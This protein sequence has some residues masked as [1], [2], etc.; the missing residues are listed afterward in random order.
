MTRRN[1]PSLRIIYLL[2]LNFYV[3]LLPAILSWWITSESPTDTAL[4][5]IV[6]AL[7]TGFRAVCAAANGLLCHARMNFVVCAVYSIPVTIR[8]WNLCLRWKLCSGQPPI[9]SSTMNASKPSLSF[10]LCMQ[11]NFFLLLLPTFAS[12]FVSGETPTEGLLAV[13]AIISI[14]GTLL[15]CLA[16]AKCGFFPPGLEPFALVPVVVF[17]ILRIPVPQTILFMNAA[18]S[19][20]VTVGLW[21]VCLRWV[22]LKGR[23][24]SYTIRMGES[25]T[26]TLT[27]SPFADE[28]SGV[29]DNEKE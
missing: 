13:S 21:N 2:Q 17:T 26:L 3:L 10:L 18:L 20:P 22:G 12:L 9:L 1:L 11:L 15:F 25:L 29:L 19:I 23:R 14:S 27:S 28:D 5:C 16:S 4:V 8:M 6:W 7:P 24:R